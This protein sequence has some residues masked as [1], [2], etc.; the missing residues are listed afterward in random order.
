[1]N[2]RRKRTTTKSSLTF[3]IVFH[4]ILILVAFVFAAREG[5]LGKKLKEL[6]VVVVPPKKPEPPKEK[7]PEPKVELPKPVEIPKPVEVPKTAPAPTPV[8][9]A[10]PAAAPPAASLPAFDFSDG[11]RAV[12]TTSDPVTL[13]KNYV[14][15]TLRSRWNRPEDMADDAFVAEVQVAVDR[16]GN[17]ENYSWISGSGNQRWDDAVRAVFKSALNI[18]RTPPTNFP[19]G[20]IVRFDVQGGDPNNAMK[21]GAP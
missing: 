11:A 16:E 21:L 2:E 5:I 9:A 12:D 10:P 6:T 13:Y 18:G 20:F 17:I 1:M 4:V 8:A 7:P 15:F 19:S 3:S 14:E